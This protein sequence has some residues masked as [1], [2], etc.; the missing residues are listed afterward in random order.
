VV[1]FTRSPLVDNLLGL[2]YFIKYSKKLASDQ[3]FT[4]QF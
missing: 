2:V 4:F 3:R 1:S